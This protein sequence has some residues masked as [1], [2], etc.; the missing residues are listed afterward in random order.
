MLPFI[1]EIR[2]S[3]ALLAVLVLSSLLFVAAGYFAGTT[4]FLTVPYSVPDAR[5]VT[6]E[7]H[8][9]GR[10]RMAFRIV[11]KRICPIELERSITDA[12]SGVVVMREKVKGGLT[13]VGDDWNVIDIIV[14]DIPPSR[15]VYQ[16]TITNTC[17][18]GVYVSKTPPVEFVVLP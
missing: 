3:P 1:R 16:T 2:R 7:V 5:T 18:N 14:P 17:V 11:R 9:G 4:T 10:L 15:Y 13:P 6:H 12:Q 8:V